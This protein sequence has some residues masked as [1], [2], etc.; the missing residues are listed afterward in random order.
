LTGG[1]RR[2]LD[3]VLDNVLDPSAIVPRDYKVNVF[4]LADGRVVQGVIQEE[5]PQ[6]VTVQTANEMVRL[7]TAE[8]EARKESQLSMMPEGLF[9]RLSP[10]EIRDLIA[11]LASPEQ[12]PL[13]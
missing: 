8:I 3:Y 13:P 5:T 12:I 6:V 10:E 2:N 4:R 11:Y 1:Q 9:E 7:P